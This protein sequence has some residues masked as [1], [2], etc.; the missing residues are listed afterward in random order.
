MLIFLRSVDAIERWGTLLVE[1][2]PKGWG[3][4]IPLIS[5]P[6][7]LVKSDSMVLNSR[8]TYQVYKSLFAY[9]LYLWHSVSILFNGLLKVIY[10]LGF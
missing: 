6:T 4:R 10:T 9:F 2:K 7:T 8:T 3:K 1:F 5:L